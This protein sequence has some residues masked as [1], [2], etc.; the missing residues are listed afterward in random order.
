MLSRAVLG[1]RRLA[2]A[3][4][5]TAVVFGSGEVLAQGRTPPLPPTPAGFDDALWARAWALHHESLVV[6][7]HCDTTSLI[8]DED[9]DM[10]RPQKRA[11]VDLEKIRTGGLDAVFYSIYVA[12]RYA[13]DETM[14]V[15]TEDMSGKPDGSARRALAM[16]DGLLRTVERNPDRMTLC[17]DTKSLRETVA[18]GRHAA[19][20]GI[21]GGHAI[22]GELALLRMFHQLGVRYMTLTHTNHNQ[23]ADT[24]ADATPR[25]GGLNRLGEKVVREMNRLGMMVDVSHVSD[26]TFFDAL[27]V[28]RAPVVLSHSSLRSLCPHPR[29]VTDDMLRA[30]AANGGVIMINYNC[31]FVDP[32]YAKRTEAVR[33]HQRIRQKAID[34]RFPKDSPEWK[35]ATDALMSR[36]TP[37]EPPDVE[38]LMQHFLRAIEIAG[39]EHVGLG[40]DF[41][42]VMCVPR[43]IDDASYLPQLTYRLLRSGVTEDGVR[44]ILGE[45]LMR[46]FR[47]VEEVAIELATEPPYRND[48]ATDRQRLPR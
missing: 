14:P 28:S 16:I 13:G 45:N 4:L 26:A 35:T 39:V 34:D 7:T 46:V 5:A 20:M 23:F 18:A 11:H 43:G 27:K 29:N 30:L 44:K 31:G 25:W 9:F 37:A 15:G 47:R 19:L 10:A 36:F 17:T 6:D 1:G 8:L 22:E 32:E 33:A 3:T 48:P 21:E 42:G 24:C 12:A 2:L 41:D 40:S 38:V